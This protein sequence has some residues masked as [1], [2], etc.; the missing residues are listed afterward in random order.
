MRGHAT[1]N[2]GSIPSPATYFRRRTPGLSSPMLI[3]EQLEPRCL[4]SRLP[5]SLFAFD[6]LGFSP[7]QAVRFQPQR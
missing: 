4:L 6:G 1:L 7:P 2:L 3:L 5:P